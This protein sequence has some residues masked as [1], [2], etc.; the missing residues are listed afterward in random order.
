MNGRVGVDEVKAAQKCK[1]IANSGRGDG[2]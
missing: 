2:G 1:T